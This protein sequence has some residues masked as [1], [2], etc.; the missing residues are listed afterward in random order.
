MTVPLEHWKAIAGRVREEAKRERLSLLAAGIAFWGT[1]SISPMLLVLVSVYGLVADPREAAGQL[2]SLTRPLPEPVAHLLVAQLSSAVRTGERGLTA[3]LSLSLVGLLWA[4]SRA[5]QALMRGLNAVLGG[6]ESHGPV[7]TRLLA[8]LYTVAAIVGVSVLL[9]L[10]AA[11]PVVLGHLGLGR[12]ARVAVS[13]ARWVALV[14]LIGAGL[15]LLYR[16]V[17]GSRRESQW[18]SVAWGVAFAM[19]ALVVVSAGLSIFVT[20]FG[21]FGQTYG[22]VAA[23]AVL[24]LWLYLSTLIVLLGAEV[25]GAI[26]RHLRDVS[27]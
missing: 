13:V 15:A 8:L 21:R 3:N 24:M 14:V 20:G 4:S 22:V 11:F 10:V 7:G 23:V 6:R 17:P 1:L 26:E 9:A 2:A 12:V 5:V 19:P 27:G 16:Y 25:N 18:R